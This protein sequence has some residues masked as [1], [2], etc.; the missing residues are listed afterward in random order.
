MVVGGLD[1]D[2][3]LYTYTIITTSS[4]KQLNFLHDRMPVILDQGSDAL[5]VWLDPSRHEWSK[6]L[7]AL[8]KPYSG[9][10]ELEV[11]PVSKEVGKVGNNSPSFIVPIASRENKSNIAN[12]FAN[13]KGAKKEDAASQDDTKTLCVGEVGKAADDGGMTNPSGIKREAE[14]YPHDTDEE[15]QP[16]RKKKPAT[17]QVGPSKSS[18]S[19]SPSK[20]QGRAKISATSNGGRSPVKG[21]KQDG[22]Q[23]ITKFFANSAA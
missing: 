5:R 11:Y 17:S 16:P 3:K 19:S 9:E 1:D 15:Q 23:K 7:Q 21:G 13:A 2:Q 12:F 4:N 8:L 6:E 22:S 20:P 10:S 14:S 18:V